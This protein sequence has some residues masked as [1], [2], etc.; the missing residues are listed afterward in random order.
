MYHDQ[1]EFVPGIFNKQGIFNIRKPINVIYHI[2]R[3]KTNRMF[4]STDIKDLDTM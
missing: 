2:N 1:L 3:K 4:T